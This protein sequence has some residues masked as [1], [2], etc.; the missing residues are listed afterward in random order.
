MSI[1]TEIQRLQNSKAD[2]KTAIKEKGVE[3]G[4]GL[5]DTYSEKIS[6]ISGD[7]YERGYNEGYENGKNSVIDFARYARS[8]QFETTK[9]LPEEITVYLDNATSL[10]DF[11]SKV[12]NTTVKHITLNVLNKIGGTNLAR[13]FNQV[14]V[15]GDNRALEHI[16]FNVDTSASTSFPQVFYMMSKLKIIDGKPIDFSSATSISWNWCNGCNVL[17]EVRVVKETIKVNIP[18]DI[19]NASDETIQSFVDGLAD[20]TGQTAQK[21]T[22][23]TDI[24]LKLTSAQVTQITN[25]NWE[26]G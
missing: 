11:W 18:V 4:S 23:H 12:K 2:I 14:N 21:V 8:F 25:K 3:V 1:A 15:S 24:I 16:T 26:I 6:E 17:E 20:L 7:Q 10:I 13:C 9:G 22:W 19:K 5:I